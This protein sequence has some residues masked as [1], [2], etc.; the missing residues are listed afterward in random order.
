MGLLCM[1]NRNCVDCGGTCDS[2][3]DDLVPLSLRSKRISLQTTAA[4]C[5]R[6]ASYVDFSGTVGSITSLGSTCLSGNNIRAA[7]TINAAGGYVFAGPVT[8]FVGYVG[9]FGTPTPTALPATG[10]N[11]RT[12]G[13]YAG[14][15]FYSSAS[16]PT[17]IYLL[18]TAGALSTA[19]GQAATNILAT[20]G[21]YPTT[22]SPS[23]FIFQDSSTLWVCDD[24]AAA[25]YGVWKLTGTIG[26]FAAATSGVSNRPYSTAVCYSITGQLEASV[27]VVYFITAAGLLRLPTSGTTSTLIV[28]AGANP[29]RGVSLVPISPSQ[30]QSQTQS[31]T[32]TPSVT[33]TRTGSQTYTPS[34]TSTRTGSQTYTPSVTSTRTGS[35]T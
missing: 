19:G 33:S 24:G 28:T 15:L 14:S 22:N 10:V 1:C 21:F 31:Q 6:A 18:G 16:A 7:I 30:T 8:P 25:S 26:T 35:Q 23:A 13:T 3:C 29:F 12:V 5:P 34:V 27:F 2:R 9:P 17:S 20:T 32:Y 4:T 11:S